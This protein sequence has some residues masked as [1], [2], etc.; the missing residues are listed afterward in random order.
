MRSRRTPFILGAPAPPKGVSATGRQAPRH[1]PPKVH[2]QTCPK[3]PT[4]PL[5]RPPK[6]ITLRQ[7]L[8]VIPHVHP[9]PQSSRRRQP[10]HHPVRNRRWSFSPRPP[11]LHSSRNPN[12]APLLHRC[13]AR[14]QPRPHLRP[15]RILPEPGPRSHS[16]F[17]LGRLHAQTPI[18]RPRHAPRIS[19]PRIRHSHNHQSHPGNPRLTTHLRSSRLQLVKLLSRRSSL[20]L[21]S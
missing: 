16:R 5:P 6:P 15:S 9:A 4:P 14:W 19:P 10:R 11:T 3:N 13:S 21:S 8:V 17:H 2:R 12:H 20:A 7:H 1:P 18:R